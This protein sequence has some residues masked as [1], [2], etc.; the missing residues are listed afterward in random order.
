MSF[1]SDQ[2][3]IGAALLTIVV[4]VALLAAQAMRVRRN[5]QDGNNDGLPQ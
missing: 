1:F 4:G 5:G 2:V 3:V